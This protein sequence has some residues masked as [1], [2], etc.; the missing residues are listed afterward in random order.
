MNVPAVQE[1]MPSVLTTPRMLALGGMLAIAVIAWIFLWQGAVVMAEMAAEKG[2]LSGL[3]MVMMRPDQPAAYLP[4]VAL[5]WVVMM[6]AMMTPAVLPMLLVFWRLA[7]GTRRQSLW[8][9]IVFGTSYLVVWSVFGLVLTLLQWA[10][11]RGAVLHTGVLALGSQPAAGLLVAA[12]MYQLT[13]LKAACLA[14]CQSP[15]AF[16]LSHWRPGAVGALRMGLAHG[17]YC[18]GCCWVLMLLMFAGGVMSI[19]SMAL[20]SLLILLERLLP[21][22]RWAAFV[23]GLLLIAWGSWNLFATLRVT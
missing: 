15:L 4:A 20:I 16:L 1:P 21:P 12:G 10:L 8:H 13:P 2:L 14:H 19:G 17:A 11:H 6:V 3:M 23:P 22:R 9:G 7:R 5:M 18:L